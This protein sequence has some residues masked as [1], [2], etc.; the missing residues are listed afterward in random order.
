MRI[1]FVLSGHIWQHT[2]PEGFR[3]AGHDVMVIC[4]DPPEKIADTLEQYR[5]QMAISIGWGKEQSS[6]NQLI[7]RRCFK[8][9]HV[10][11]IYWS[12]ED[13]GYTK[14][15]S[16]PL[17]Q[18]MKPD[19]IFT[20]CHD[21]V[22]YFQRL[23]FRAAYMDF[24][25]SPQIH[26]DLHGEQVYDIAVV[27]NAYPKILSKHPEHFRHHSLNVL[28]EPLLKHKLRVDFWGRDWTKLQDL[29]GW[30][31]PPEWIH[32]PVNYQDTVKIY[33]SSRILLGL[34]NYRN[35]VTQRTY[36]IMGSGSFLLTVDT[37]GVRTILKPGEDLAC[38]ASPD[39][40]R[41]LVHYYL[42]NPEQRS[43]IAAHGQSSIATYTYR[44]RAEYML[45]VLKKA[46]IVAEG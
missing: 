25:F 7:L 45:D 42:K 14:E 36:E 34:Q 13:P 9:A 12:V 21:T 22:D 23:G 39:Q 20:I 46:S 3:E 40:T 10:P 44:H 37:P 30:E 19:F 1:L 43:R 24:G 2:L 35:Q 6:K 28:V 11:H 18:K 17:I 32:P 8:A 15:F 16:V 27:A 31:I 5:P 41:E 4:S 33:H 38:S 26:H 29:Y